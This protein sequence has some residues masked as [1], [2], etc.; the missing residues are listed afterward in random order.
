MARATSLL[1]YVFRNLASNY[2]GS[3]DLADAEDDAA[4]TV[5]DGARERAPLLPLELPRE[6]GARQRRRALRVVGL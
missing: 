2:L 1:D 5:G 4:D 6:D 3:I